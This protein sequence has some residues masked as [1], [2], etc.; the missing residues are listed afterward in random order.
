M[1]LY[2]NRQPFDC[3]LTASK[4]IFWKSLPKPKYL[5]DVCPQIDGIKH[6][7]EADK[8]NDCIFNSVVF[9][10]PFLVSK[11]AM[12]KIKERFTY[13]ESVDE[14]YRANNEMLE[15]SYR[16]LK[17]QGLLVVK[18]MDICH[19]N[20]QVWISDFVIKKA[21]ELGFELIEKFILLSNLRLFARTRQQKV[22]RKY[23]SY[24]FVF[25]KKTAKIQV[26]PI[27]AMLWD[28]DH[29]LFDTRADEEVRK[30]S[31]IKNWDV[32]YSKIPE[33][34]LYDGWREVF[35][36]AK[37]KGVKIAI[38]STAKKELIQK[39]LYYFGLQCDV[40]IGWQRCYQK[41]HAHLVEMALNKLHV[42]KE[43]V[44]SVGDSIIDREM[45]KNGEVKFLGAIWDSQEVEELKTGEN[46]DSP[47]GILKYI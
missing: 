14:I 45:S 34:R 37:T 13:F 36:T 46:I 15:R 12:S 29:T 28:F 25:R 26:S 39:T 20:K 42:N 23:H 2:N 17:E 21:E 1:R 44:I 16:L 19:G 27:K 22:A 33:Y 6:L 38:I 11:G 35:E 41:P 32:I 9:D 8:L 43:N 40:V 7:S 4:C 5:Y 47:L 24:F 18:T 10:L 3:D 31:T 30:N